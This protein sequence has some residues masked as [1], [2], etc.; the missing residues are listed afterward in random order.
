MFVMGQSS[1]FCLSFLA[2]NLCRAV[3]GFLLWGLHMFGGRFYIMGA[4]VECSTILNKVPLMTVEGDAIRN[5]LCPNNIVSAHIQICLNF[6][7][8]EESN[9]GAYFLLLTFF[10]NINF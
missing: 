9:L 5:R 4:N 10:D 3:M 1:V 7:F 8:I 2:G 6:F